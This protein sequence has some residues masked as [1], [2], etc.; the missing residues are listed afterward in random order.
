MC[1]CACVCDGGTQ[2]GVGVQVG[3]CAQGLWVRGRCSSHTPR[4]VWPP[5]RARGAGVWLHVGVRL[6]RGCARTGGRGAARAQ[7]CTA[8]HGG[9]L[10]RAGSGLRARHVCKRGCAAVG[11]TDACGSSQRAPGVPKN[12]F[13]FYPWRNVAPGEVG[14]SP[15][16][17][18]PKHQPLP[19]DRCGFISGGRGWEAHR[20]GALRLRN[21][22]LNHTHWVHYV[23][24]ITAGMGNI[25]HQRLP[26][27]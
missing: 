27:C 11:A 26:C 5:A 15:Q 20:N 10:A 19:E 22:I 24:C 18:V 2:G 4:G 25:F 8:L 6:R 21:V 23:E 3:V 12:P 7:A 13:W 1:A 9:V 17:S 16:P 14:G